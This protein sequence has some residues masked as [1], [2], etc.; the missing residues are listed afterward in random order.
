MAIIIDM[1]ELV[2]PP[3]TFFS[4]EVLIECGSGQSML[5]MRLLTK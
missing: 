2:S 3:A 5:P 1:F 4:T